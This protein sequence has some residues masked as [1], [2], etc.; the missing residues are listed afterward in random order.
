MQMQFIKTTGWEKGTAA[1]SKRLQTELKKHR[2]VLWL[3]CGGSNIAAAVQVMNTIDDVA[4]EH[5]AI[6][7]TD[8]R[9][10]AVGHEH[11]NARQLMDAG[12]H[13]KQAIFMPMLA[14]GFSVEETQERYAQALQRAFEHADCIIAQFGIGA[15]GHIAGILPHSEAATAEAPVIAYDAPPYTRVTLT[16]PS[17]RH[18]TAAYA[19]VQG[20]EKRAALQRL[21]DEQLS[22]EEQPSQI[23]KALPEAYV[24]NDQIGEAS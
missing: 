8:E 16:F 7:L 1:L 11:S 15:D 3:T 23:L 21:R 9:F 5:L 20:D 2:Y 17:L 24:F 14:P 4:S 19:L 6:F 18:I 10:G 13:P 22:V 12:F